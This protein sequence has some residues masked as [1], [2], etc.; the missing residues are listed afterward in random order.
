MTATTKIQ[1]NFPMTFILP[2]GLPATLQCPLLQ[3]FARSRPQILL[4][5][6]SPVRKKQHHQQRPQTSMMKNP[7]NYLKSLQIQEKPKL[8]LSKRLCTNPNLRHTTD[9][10]EM[11]RFKVSLNL[12][13]THLHHSHSNKHNVV[14]Q[15][16]RQARP[17]PKALT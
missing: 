8:L 6:S 17:P 5:L 1:W 14:F 11:K 7:S 15:P 10:S 16:L 3:V 2:L 13:N 9:H 12:S 4:S